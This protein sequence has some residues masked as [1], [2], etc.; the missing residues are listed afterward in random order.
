MGRIP[1]AQTIPAA[2]QPISFRLMAVEGAMARSV[3]DLVLA[4][5]ILSGWHVRDPFSVTAP[6]KGPA[7]PKKAALVTEMPHSVLP[8]STTA[9]IRS[10][11]EVL[12]SAGWEVEEV[13]APELARINEIW[14]YLLGMDLQFLVHDMQPLMSEGALGLLHKLLGA[15]NPANITTMELFTERDR[16]AMEWSRF[17]ETWPV[18]IGPTWADLPFLHDADMDPAT[19]MQTTLSRLQFITPGNLLGL[20]SVALPMGIDSGLPTGIQIY[21]ER[22]REDLCLEVS[23][24]IESRVGQITPI[25]PR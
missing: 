13:S 23:G 2:L 17:F 10:A 12:R 8:A 15:F 18:V 20:P 22:W 19:G 5:E 7:A 14:A 1:L 24:L 9:A 21:A 3:A 11:G 4:L 25:D 16:L 6:L